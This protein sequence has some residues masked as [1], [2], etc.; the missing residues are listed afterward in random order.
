ME[1]NAGTILGDGRSGRTLVLRV[2]AKLDTLSGSECI[3]LPRVHDELGGSQQALQSRLGLIGCIHLEDLLQIVL[4]YSV[5]A[6]V[7]ARV[8]EVGEHLFEFAEEQRL[9][10]R[11]VCRHSRPRPR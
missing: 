8:M 5:G 4:G 2:N 9:K 1:L 7:L 6:I 11:L 10:N 3:L